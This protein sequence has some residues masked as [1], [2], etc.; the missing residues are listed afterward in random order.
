MGFRVSGFGVSGY[1]VSGLSGLGFS[2]FGGFGVQGLGQTG[3]G[4]EGF[5]ASAVEFVGC[6]PGQRFQGLGIVGFSRGMGVQPRA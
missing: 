2:S 3:S 6:G 4:F 1:R 5:R